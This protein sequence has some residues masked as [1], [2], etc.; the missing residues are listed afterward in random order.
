MN[1]GDK[2]QSLKIK[3]PLILFIV[4]VF[5]Y[6]SA[7][8]FLHKKFDVVSSR[9][10]ENVKNII[11]ENIKEKKKGNSAI[12]ANLPESKLSPKITVEQVQLEQA[13]KV[14]RFPLPHKYDDNQKLMFRIE[15][16]GI[17][18]NSDFDIMARDLGVRT[19]EEGRVIVTIESLESNNSSVWAIKDRAMIDLL[20]PSQQIA[21]DLPRNREARHFGIFICSDQSNSRRCKGKPVADLVELSRQQ[22]KNPHIL[23]GDEISDKIYAFYYFFIE[24]DYMRILVGSSRSYEEIN[25]RL[26]EDAFAGVVPRL[27]D[28]YIETY[29]SSL[30]R[31]LKS[32][33][34]EIDLKGPVIKVPYFN[35]Y[36]CVRKKND[37]NF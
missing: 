10:S 14:Q 5:F 32:F 28:H 19:M 15:P 26:I 31:K 2:K 35:I 12:K 23:E 37:L 22:V 8:I 7:A 11:I 21:A 30:H 16:E 17:C 4:M 36:K 9:N 3:L 24:S 1:K 13:A 18:Q 34:L 25:W 6:L 20:S 29:V 27:F 33:P